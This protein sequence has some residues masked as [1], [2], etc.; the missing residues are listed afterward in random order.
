MTR[1]EVPA[2]KPPTV[3]LIAHDGRK[4]E[5]LAFAT[6]NR[7]TLLQCGLVATANLILMSPLLGHRPTE[8]G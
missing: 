6:W 7:A 1:P 5:L 4:T 3:A 2:P 8:A